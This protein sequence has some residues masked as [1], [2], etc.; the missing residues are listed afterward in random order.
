MI[1]DHHYEIGHKHKVCEDYATSGMLDSLAFAIVSDGCSASTDVDF[2]CRAMAFAAKD[3]L[4]NGMA[5]AP[6]KDL[7]EFIIQ[8]AAKNSFAFS[9]LHPKALDATLLMALVNDDQVRLL[10]YGDGVA[11]I[12]KTSGYEVVHV[13]YG[14]PAPFYLS[15]QLDK[16]RLKEYEGSM[17]VP[18]EVT[19]TVSSGGLTETKP[20]RVPYANPVEIIYPRQD[21]TMISVISD[22]INSFREGDDAPISYKDVVD[23]FTVYKSVAGVFQSRRML[24]FKGVCQ[25]LQRTHYDDISVATIIVQPEHFK[26]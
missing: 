11:V 12:R 15:Y 5:F 1:T 6:A 24:F 4:L 22:G 23:E 7:G 21:V 25:K 19:T 9:S 8:R 10:I 18:K 26:A 16:D 14:T 2:G 3:A 13:E 17:D 20:S